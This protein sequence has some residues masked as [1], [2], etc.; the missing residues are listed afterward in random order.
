MNWRWCGHKTVPFS[1][2]RTDSLSPKM[3]WA[4]SAHSKS[5][6]MND[7]RALEKRAANFLSI[8]QFS[9]TKSKLSSPW[10]HIL[11]SNKPAINRNCHFEIRLSK[12]WCTDREI[13]GQKTINCGTQEAKRAKSVDTSTKKR[14]KGAMIANHKNDVV[15]VVKLMWLLITSRATHTVESLL[16]NK[17]LL[18]TN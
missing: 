9:A 13:C 8:N 5:A 1:Y 14:N 12:V 4:G 7:I 11:V 2:T 15:N 18:N 16:S 3:G 10:R 6:T 17:I